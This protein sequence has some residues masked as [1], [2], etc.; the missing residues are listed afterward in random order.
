MGKPRPL[1]TLF[2]IALGVALPIDAMAHA[3]RPSANPP[4]T[5]GADPVHRIIDPNDASHPTLVVCK[6]DA[7]SGASI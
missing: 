5:A 2:V 4:A 6:G 7:T 3:E 1:A